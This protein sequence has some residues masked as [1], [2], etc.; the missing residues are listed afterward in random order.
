MVSFHSYYILSSSP[1]NTAE[2]NN[3][4]LITMTL[5]FFDV[6][7]QQKKKKSVWFSLQS[8]LAL[9]DQFQESHRWRSSFF[10]IRKY[11][12]I[13]KYLWFLLRLQHI[14][15]FISLQP[16]ACSHEV[17]HVRMLTIILLSWLFITKVSYFCKKYK[18][19]IS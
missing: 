3:K 2:N 5:L 8:L 14:S 12:T 17:I 15:S 10:F 16:R 13:R 18:H 1:S 11:Y 4:K 6:F 19:N 9:D 7:L